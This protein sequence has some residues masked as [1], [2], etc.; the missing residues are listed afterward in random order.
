[1]DYRV[2]VFLG[3][4]S[5]GRYFEFARQREYMGAQAIDL[6]E[7]A[8]WCHTTDEAKADQCLSL[9]REIVEKT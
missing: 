5:N 2:S 6:P 8:Q 3:V 1:M 4:F 9:Y 7:R